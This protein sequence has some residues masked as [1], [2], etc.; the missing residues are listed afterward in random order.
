MEIVF[1]C[2]LCLD[3]NRLGLLGKGEVV[4]DY[5]VAL[6]TFD[7]LGVKDVLSSAFTVCSHVCQGTAAA[8][9]FG[10][11]IW[12]G[13]SQRDP[14]HRTGRAETTPISSLLQFC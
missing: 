8:V 7:L 12:N 11:M 14:Q 9:P 13:S 1:D 10:H 4:G 2:S 6:C 3:M 5:A